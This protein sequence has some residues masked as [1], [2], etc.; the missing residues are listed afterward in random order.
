MAYPLLSLLYSLSFP[1]LA[2]LR[3]NKNSPSFLEP[4]KKGSWAKS[5]FCSSH[6]V[7]EQTQ[8]KRLSPPHYLLLSNQP[9]P[10]P[11]MFSEILST[12][13]NTHV[14]PSLSLRCRFCL[15]LCVPL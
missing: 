8:Q 3:N 1:R 4:S 13:N 9:L 12:K 10:Y 11:A 6:D 15:T 14:N 2:T 5:S 7:F